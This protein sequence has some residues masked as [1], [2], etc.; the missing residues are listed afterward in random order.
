V[1]RK[2][3]HTLTC[4]NER[5]PKPRREF[6]GAKEEQKYC[7]YECRNEGL[8]KVDIPDPDVLTGMAAQERFQN[9]D[10]SANLTAIARE[11]GVDHKTLRKWLE[12]HQM[13]L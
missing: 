13:E 6:L 7:S 12:H 9:G 3:K 8:R 10:G 4:H 5:C 2:K 11:F 1:S